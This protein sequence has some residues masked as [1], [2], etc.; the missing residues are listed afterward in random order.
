[1]APQ[2]RVGGGATGQLLQSPGVMPGLADIR[3]MC[4]LVLWDLRGKV[5]KKSRF[6]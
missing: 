2:T 3:R 5:L 6:G 4:E 1:M